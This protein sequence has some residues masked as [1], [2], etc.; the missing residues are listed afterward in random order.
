MIGGIK[1]VKVHLGCE[2]QFEMLFNELKKKV[3]TKESGNVYY[4]LYR[5]PNETGQYRVMERYVD[6]AALDAHQHS[7]YGREYFP[8]IRAI[9]E[10][11]SVDYLES[12]EDSA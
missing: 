11:I 6:Q 10:S 2:K 8:K 12:V 5:V 1:H 7:A 4:D 9:L 3:N